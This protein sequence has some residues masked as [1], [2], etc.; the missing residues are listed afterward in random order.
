MIA[1]VLAAMFL[2]LVTTASGQR[3]CS[4]VATRRIR[5]HSLFW[6]RPCSR[7]TS[8]SS[9]LAQFSW[10]IGVHSATFLREHRNSRRDRRYT[11][12]GVR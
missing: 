7:H 10:K 11:Y 4:D 6:Y 3:R 5:Q 12:A 1:L 9:R 8:G 2:G